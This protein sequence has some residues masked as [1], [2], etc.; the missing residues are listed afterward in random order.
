MSD[1]ASNRVTIDPSDTVLLLIDHQAGLLLTVRDIDAAELRT[2]VSVL[3]TLG[4]LLSIPTFTTAS[5]PDGPNGRTIPEV[6]SQAPRAR[7]IARR[8]EINA[9]DNEDFVSAVRATGRKT[10]L[11]AGIWTS[12]CVALPALAAR[13]EGYR[14]YAV[15]DASG[16]VS[17]FVSRVTLARIVQAGVVPT[18]VNAVI[19]ELQHRWRGPLDADFAAMYMKAVPSYA[20]VVDCHTRTK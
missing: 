17:E 16:D 1:A 6:R 11:I 18:S 5:E 3:A 7:H 13:A 4:E 15:M 12:V 19:S 2:N 14:V 20:A 10:L 9:W 8:G